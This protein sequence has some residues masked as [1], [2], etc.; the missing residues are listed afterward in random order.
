MASTKI[1]DT[2][3]CLYCGKRFHSAMRLAHH[4]DTCHQGWVEVILAKIGVEVPRTYP[5]PE[6]RKAI[7]QAFAA[8]A[9]AAPN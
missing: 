9:P 1:H 6:Y 2:L 4:L 3:V 5:V 8:H 7:A